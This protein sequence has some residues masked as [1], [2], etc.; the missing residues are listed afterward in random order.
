MVL[1]EQVR[2]R[3]DALNRAM[4]ELQTS[5]ALLR[6]AR[7]RAETA[8]QH[9]IDAIESISDAFVL[10]D[11]GQRILLFN[12]RFQALWGER[13]GRIRRGMSLSEMKRLALGSG[14][15][16][17]GA[18]QRRA[19]PHPLSSGGRPLGAGQ[20]AADPARADW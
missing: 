19:A 7:G 3:T 14:L 20:R 5:N 8:D 4:T 16:V 13:Q 2:E 15:A 1:A 12:R 17:R 9:L 18:R 10:F 11:A 6:E